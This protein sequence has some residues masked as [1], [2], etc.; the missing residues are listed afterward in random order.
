MSAAIESLLALAQSPAPAFGSGLVVSRTGS[1]SRL[2]RPASRTR[3]AFFSG[4]IP[5]PIEIAGLAAAVII[6]VTGEG[7]C[8]TRGIE[9]TVVVSSPTATAAPA[10]PAATASLTLTARV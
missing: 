4:A 2:V 9:R 6:A 3:L 8:I 10:S 7:A 1:R 5:F